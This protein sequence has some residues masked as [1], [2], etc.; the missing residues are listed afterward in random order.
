MCSLEELWFGVG[1]DFGEKSQCD[2]RTQVHTQPHTHNPSLTA[3]TSTHMDR[4]NTRFYTDE[5]ICNFR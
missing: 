4:M 1:S 5:D 3:S 2:D